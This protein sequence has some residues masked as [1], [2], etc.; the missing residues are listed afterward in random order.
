MK[1]KSFINLFFYSTLI[2]SSFFITSVNATQT[3]VAGLV[4]KVEVRYEKLH[5]ELLL[6]ENEVGDQRLISQ[7]KILAL[8]AYQ[9]ES[10]DALLQVYKNDETAISKAEMKVITTGIERFLEEEK[11]AYQLIHEQVKE[12]RRAMAKLS[13]DDLIKQEVDVAN[14]Q[15]TLD[16]L[17][18][19]S[20]SMT[21]YLAEFE[22]NTARHDQQLISEINDRA[23]E[24]SLL[25]AYA[26]KEHHILN[27]KMLGASSFEKDA[28]EIELRRLEIK[29]E[30]AAKTLKLS[31]GILE[32]YQTNVDNYRAVLISNVGAEGDEIFEVTVI[33]RILNNWLEIFLNWLG[34]NALD[35][36]INTFIFMLILFVFYMFSNVAQKVVTKATL[37]SKLNVSKL[38]RKFVIQTT[39]RVILFIGFMV[40]FSYLGIELAPL[41]T[42]FGV[43]GIVIGFALQGTLSNFASGVMMLLYRPFDVGDMIIA[44]GE[45]GTVEK[46]SLVN[47]TIHT[48]DNRRVV[49]PNNLIWE[50]T[51]TNISAEHL[52]RVDLVFGI[53]YGDDLLLAEKVM[54]EEMVQHKKVLKTPEPIVKVAELGDSSVNFWVR[55][56]VEN[57]DYWDV[58][59][60]LT[61]A[62]K[63]RLDKEGI[64]I[65]FPQRDVHIYSTEKPLVIS[66]GD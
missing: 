36:A 21:L 5:K 30:S 31:I 56:W 14:K 27:S 40:A 54:M 44:G 24:S 66:K 49:L 15:D 7:L 57:E 34:H 53:G 26:G 3:N 47:T 28:L 42:G 22:H 12:L 9:N 39:G 62:I 52:R 38:L 29:Q 32:L 35:Y 65:P 41:L 45:Q 19:H 50:G 16:M 60:D 11:G 59:W 13:G 20:H 10:M 4:S 1:C 18:K 63:L 55:P 43:A 8:L 51:I 33:T 58:H 61:K 25:L 17:L 37:N 23:I 48:I 64:S 2:V 46:L 6:A